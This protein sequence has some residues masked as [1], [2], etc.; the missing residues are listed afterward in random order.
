VLP[1][2]EITTLIL[3]QLQRVVA[4]DSAKLLLNQGGVLRVTATAGTAR[5]PRAW[6]DQ[7]RVY[8]PDEPA[9][10]GLIQSRRALVLADAQT[11]A[12]T[13]PARLDAQARGWI[14]AP[15]LLDDDLI[16]LLT[17][18]SRTTGAYSD[19]DGQLVFA[20]ASLAA[21]AIRNV[22]LFDEVHRFA[23]ELEQRVVERTVALAEL[24]GEQRRETSKSQAILQSLTEGVMMVDHQQRVVLVNPAAERLLGIPAAA[25]VQQP[26]ARLHEY[27]ER[28]QSAVQRREMIYTGLLAGLHALDAGGPTQRRVLELVA[29]NQT[30][31][32]HF[33]EVVH[34]P[35]V[36]H[37][38]VIVLSDLTR[39]VE[40]D[41]ARRAFISGVSRELRDPLTVIQGY[42]DLLLLGTA[43]AL[44]KEQRSFLGVVKGSVNRLTRFNNDIQMIGLIDSDRIT[45]TLSSERVRMTEI[46]HEVLQQIDPDARHKSLTMQVDAAPD[47]P[48]VVVDRAM[49]T[50]A[51]RHLAANAVKYSYPGGR[52][53]LRAYAGKYASVE[54]ETGDLAGPDLPRAPD[55]GPVGSVVV[56]VEDMGVGITPEQQGRLFE[57]FYRADNPLRGEN[58]GT[59]LGLSIARSLIEL[60]GGTIWVRSR[61]GEGSTFAFSLP[62]AEQVM[63]DG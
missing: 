51:I 42:V 15:L 50:L 6:S 62:P 9:L 48:E 47:L 52:I 1:P 32:L 23:A 21:Q 27:G 34:S 14:G 3:N 35:D 59:G 11:D 30:I 26:L 19:E 58:S 10:D 12:A 60:H 56:A 44:N 63:D 36:R 49:I 25:I 29:P 46:L 24:L 55:S 61:I 18:G 4:Y 54:P 7:V 45:E 28:S 13:L 16:G 40:A 22:R 57:R 38:S 33:A 41:R 17:V 31:A 8:L 5:V 2:D 37:G 43:G 39:V 20:L 53:V